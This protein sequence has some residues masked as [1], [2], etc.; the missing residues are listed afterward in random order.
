MLL[1]ELTGPVVIARLGIVV[2]VIMWALRRPLFAVVTDEEWS[3]VAGLPVGLRDVQRDAGH[4]ATELV[5]EVP[6]VRHVG[7]RLRQRRSAG[8]RDVSQGR[9]MV[10]GKV[11]GTL[12]ASRKRPCPLIASSPFLSKV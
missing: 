5:R 9:A 12:V 3:R 2:A 6:V 8:A 7:Q 1:I 4:R 11:I 10:L